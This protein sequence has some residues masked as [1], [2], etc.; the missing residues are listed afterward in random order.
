LSVWDHIRCEMPLPGAPADG[1]RTFM[2]RDTPYQF[3]EDYT[4]TADGRLI[5]QATKW[6]P[7]EDRPD[8]DEPRVMRHSFGSRRPAPDQDEEVP[9]NGD[10]TFTDLS[11]RNSPTYVACFIDGRCIR[12]FLEE[13][14]RQRM[15]QAR[16]RMLMDDREGG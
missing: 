2:T 15:E 16:R 10:L 7:R 14:Y 5:H 8:P 4:I 9:F 11:A 13:E 6:I 12:I 3:M 1:T